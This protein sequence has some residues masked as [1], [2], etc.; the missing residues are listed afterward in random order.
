MEYHFIEKIAKLGLE[1]DES[2]LIKRIMTAL[3]FLTKHTVDGYSAEI[4]LSEESSGTRKLF[5]LLFTSQG[6]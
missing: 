1:M 4:V 5:E 3:R 6:I 2:D